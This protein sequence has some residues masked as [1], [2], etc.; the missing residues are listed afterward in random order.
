MTPRTKRRRTSTESETGDGLHDQKA[1][2]EAICRPA[3]ALE[4]ESWNG[5]CEI[6]SEPVGPVSSTEADLMFQGPV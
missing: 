2:V 6:E 5:F 4:K 1:S 3:T